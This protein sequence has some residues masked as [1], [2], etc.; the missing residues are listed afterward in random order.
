MTGKTARYRFYKWQNGEEKDLASGLNNHVL[1]RCNGVSPP[2]DNG[3]DLN[4]GEK[5]TVK[6]LTESGHLPKPLLQ[7]AETP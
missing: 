6:F 7:S 5:V 2:L 3:Y 1:P 4:H